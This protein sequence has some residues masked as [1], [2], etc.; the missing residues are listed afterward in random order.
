MAAPVIARGS[1]APA[2]WPSG[3]HHDELRVTE[4][5]AGL[6]PDHPV[7]PLRQTQFP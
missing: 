4:V 6:G 1:D 5:R 2:N 3:T 7:P